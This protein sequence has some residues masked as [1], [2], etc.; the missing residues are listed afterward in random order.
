MGQ[1]VAVAEKPSP[2]PGVVRFET[3][4]SFTGMGHERFTAPE[5]AVGDR[6][7]AVIARRFFE[8]GKVDAVHVYQ[9]VVT[10]D[11]AKGH[12]SAGLLEV[13][14]GLYTYYRPGFVPPPL[15]MPEEEKPA[16]VPAGDDAAGDDASLAA[17]ASKVPAHLLE[18]SRAAKA[19]KV[20][21]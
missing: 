11:L 14:E 10:V 6:P 8:T 2:R 7:A 1:P 15:V 18:R 3:N 19:R 17:A 20:G 16:P 21:G 9:N 5:Q 12:T 4:R 13:L